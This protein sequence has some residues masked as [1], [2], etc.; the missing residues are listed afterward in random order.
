M[1]IGL[2]IAIERELKAFLDCGSDRTDEIVNGRT[3]YHTKIGDHEVLA[4]CS[5]W[6]EI[7]AAS[8]TQLLITACGAEAV[9][10]FGVTGALVPALGVEDL[11]LVE[12]VCHYD[13]DTSSI[14]DVAPHQYVEFPDR[15]IP[16]DAGLL[17][18]ARAILPDLRLTAVASGDR[19]VEDRA[20]KQALAALGCEICDMEIAAIARVCFLNHVPC[21]SVKCISDTLEGSGADFQTNVERSAAKAFAVLRTLIQSL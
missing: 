1:K 9:F 3:V 16:L 5:G 17:N 13:F 20:D 19:F 4:L 12:K 10:N 15:F 21:L 14:D 18:R 11:F 7:D 8:G 6:G 2:L